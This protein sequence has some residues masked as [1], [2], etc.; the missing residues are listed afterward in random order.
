MI[1]LLKRRAERDNKLIVP[2]TIN[3]PIECCVIKCNFYVILLKESKFLEKL[4]NPFAASIGS[5][6]KRKRI[7]IN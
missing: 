2:P 6:N 3:F 1:Q 5:N 4:N 7:S